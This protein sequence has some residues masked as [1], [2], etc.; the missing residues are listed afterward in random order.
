LA[1]VG[2]PQGLAKAA[3]GPWVEA[4]DAAVLRVDAEVVVR[5]EAEEVASVYLNSRR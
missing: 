4:A 5:A 2:E 1:A 3:L